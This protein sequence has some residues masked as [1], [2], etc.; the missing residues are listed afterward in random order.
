MSIIELPI[1][2]EVDDLSK[3]KSI[4][5]LGRV[6]S[7]KSA[8]ANIMTSTNAF[9]EFMENTMGTSVIQTE[10][11]KWLDTLTLVTD[12]PG[13]D[14]AHSEVQSDVAIMN[15]IANHVNMFTHKLHA[16]VI[17]SNFQDTRFSG[18]FNR[19]MKLYI[20]LFNQK[21]FLSH[22]CFA[23]TKLNTHVD[24]K[25]KMEINRKE[26]LEHIIEL[27]AD[28]Y[29]EKKE[30]LQNLPTELPCFFFDL[31]ELD[32]FSVSE[33]KKMCQHIKTLPV[34]SIEHL[35]PP[36][37]ARFKL[38][39]SYDTPIDDPGHYELLKSYENGSLLY[40]LRTNKIEH[41]ETWLSVDGV[42]T[43]YKKPTDDERKIEIKPEFVAT[44]HDTHYEDD[45][46]KFVFMPENN[47]EL[48][49]Q[50]CHKIE[51]DEDEWIS[52]DN[53][54]QKFIFNSK[55]TPEIKNPVLIKKGEEEDYQVNYILE[56]TQQSNTHKLMRKVGLFV[57]KRIDKW[58]TYDGQEKC[59]E[60]K[61]SPQEFRKTLIEPKYINDTYSEK[62]LGDLFK[63]KLKISHWEDATGNV[64]IVQD[65]G[66]AEYIGPKIE[67]YRPPDP[68]PAPKDPRYPPYRPPDPI[69]E[70]KITYINPAINQRLGGGT[71]L[72]RYEKAINGVSTGEVIK[73]TLI[74]SKID[75]DRHFEK[76][77]KHPNTQCPCKV[78]KITN[79][80]KET[81]KDALGNI[82]H[83]D[84]VVKRTR[85]W[86]K[87]D[88]GCHDHK[89]LCGQDN[90]AYL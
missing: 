57:K 31:K 64:D 18:S 22:L 14:D 12:A 7:G 20:A 82:T 3:Y 9:P 74:D 24:Y 62:H 26:Y 30:Y 46:P 13:L 63:Q 78:Y 47:P 79:I 1:N 84:R 76:N 65:E 44:R 81:W 52:V 21:D 90:W 48:F 16:I 43:P 80:C 8:I 86:K 39:N 2:P 41:W 54:K 25:A 10:K 35:I 55:K 75:I 28:I 83:V 15:C 38:M 36:Q 4:L 61:I 5:L 66:K 71:V 67:P 77:E 27:Y 11:G 69:P 60:I 19:F 58:K 56:D 49:S 23:F 70:Q 87:H 51:Y 85:I 42:A 68:I 34:L 88:G 45:G 73:P 33:L 29:S 17:V 53:V 50:K 32:P 89:K 59:I 72:Y 40:I 37:F 6:G